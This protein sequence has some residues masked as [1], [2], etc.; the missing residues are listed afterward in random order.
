MKT[1]HHFLSLFT[2]VFFITTSPVFSQESE[3]VFED[4]FQVNP[5]QELNKDSSEDMMSGRTS[6]MGVEESSEKI[7]SDDFEIKP[8]DIKM[9]DESLF[10]PEENNTNSE[11]GSTLSDSEPV[12]IEANTETAQAP[13]SSGVELVEVRT[14]ESI[15]YPYKQRQHQWGLSFSFGAENVS[16][17][18]LISQFD[19]KSF[20]TLYGS[21]GSPMLNLEL[22]PRYN[23]SWG[24][25]ALLAG[26]GLLD[27]ADDR[28]GAD[29]ELTVQRYSATAVFYL[30][31]IWGEPYF[32][33]YV[34]GGIWMADYSEIRG[35][36]PD[37][38]SNTS[39]D[40]GYHYRVG[41]LIGLDWIEPE[42]TLKSRRET[43]MKA[44]FV[45]VYASSAF[46]SESKPDPDLENEWNLGASLVFEY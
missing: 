45:N 2:L 30:D 46:M 38:V 21:S 43:G 44:M 35:A 20:E 26:Y 39:T 18:G 32:V 22:G 29:D 40:L 12:A 37:E 31:N 36:F 33:P 6:L 27:I 14:N 23:M 16:Y 15:Y 1:I 28:S 7:E 17:P 42:S 13:K 34:G 41:A 24:S 19:E 9:S 8:E 11:T 25:L 5:S 10:R 4:A 3:D